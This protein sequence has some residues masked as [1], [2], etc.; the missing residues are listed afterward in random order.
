MSDILKVTTPVQGYENTTKTNP[1]SPND[2]KIQNI[3]DPSKVT[4]PDG[5]TGGTDHSGDEN[6]FTFNY[7][8]N[9]DKFLYLIRN[10]PSL[11]ESLSGVL[12]SMM[13]NMAGTV[14][15]GEFSQ[16]VTA[17]L[18][19]MKMTDTQILDF[20]KDQSS[21]SSKFKSPFFDMLREV[22]QETN[23]IDMKSGILNFL[24]KFN[25]TASMEHTFGNIAQN[26]GQILKSIPTSYREPLSE[27][28]SRLM[29]G[30][31]A[32]ANVNNSILLKNEIIPFLSQYISRT[33][34]LGKTRDLITLLTLNIAR[35][36]NSNPD[37]LQN[38]IKSLLGFKTVKGRLGEIDAQQLTNLL[39]NPKTEE[40]KYSI[41]DKLV[42]I[43]RRGLNGENGFESKGIFENIVNAIL[44]NESVYMP[45]MHMI[46]PA[47]IDGKL[48]FSELWVDPDEQNGK[49]EGD[50]SRKIKLFIKFDIS[51]IGYF[52]LIINWQNGNVDLQLFYPEK[53]SSLEKEIKK[54]IGSIVEKN[55][56]SFRSLMVEKS[57]KPKTVA[58]VFPQIK[59]RKN[60]INVRI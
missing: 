60:T 39:L 32:E 27:M 58:E 38:D 30:N 12:L 42:S 47:N 8:S 59:E 17:F 50:D 35:Y 13:G 31:S 18:E 56:L 4:R 1:I 25:D 54:G 26:L 43:I 6:N 15:E 2:P 11:T 23:S 51:E 45:L 28:M 10:T 55:G 33:H 22:F 52:D 5:R 3:V 48:L 36:E 16:D 44:V 37:D 20:L 14:E 29:P 57:I 53:L 40:E 19:A 9:F 46:L 21:L 41:T 7:G 34:D 49:N 24:R